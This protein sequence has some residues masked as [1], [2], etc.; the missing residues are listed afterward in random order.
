[1]N[2]SILNDIS[3]IRLI[4]ISLFVTD[5]ALKLTH[6]D[7]NTNLFLREHD[8]TVHNN[9]EIYVCNA[10]MEK[11]SIHETLNVKEGSGRFSLTAFHRRAVHSKSARSN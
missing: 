1:M 5:L 11:D 9:Q 7:S 6:H 2:I 10:S 4:T 3:H 8:N